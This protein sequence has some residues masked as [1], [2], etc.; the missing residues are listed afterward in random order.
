MSVSIIKF[1]ERFVNDDNALLSKWSAVHHKMIFEMHRQDFFV[2]STKVGTELRIE[3][4]G[5]FPASA[6][7]EVG[8]D[9]YIETPNGSGVFEV[10]QI[11][12]PTIII[13][14]IG[15]ITT[16]T[17]AGYINNLLRENYFIRTNIWGVDSANQYFFIGQSVNKP[18]TTGRAKVDVSSFL[19]EAVDYI[20]E[21]QYIVLNQKDTTLGGSYNITFS[22]NWT[23]FEG[24]F[25]GLSN[26]FLRF[27]VNSAKQ[28]QDVL[29]ENMGEYV[30]FFIDSV[31]AVPLAKF[32][33]DFDRPTYFPGFPF[34][35]SFIYSEYLAGIET[36]KHEEEFDINDAAIG[37]VDT[38]E[39]SN[40]EVQE[41]NRLLINTGYGSNVDDIDVW[42]E[43]DGTESCLLY[44]QE[45]FIQVG[46]VQD[47][48]GIPLVTDPV[49]ENPVL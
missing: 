48:C 18:D 36:F 10:I 47:V 24:E 11:I 20:D 16:L 33:S 13:I 29:G 9:I 14:E 4:T 49:E 3:I 37:P 17:G 34:S 1:P 23:G 45:G 6:E 35:L 32:L 46:Y 26:Q 42:L 38:K 44:Y 43:S 40:A 5:V 28:L 25:S 12:D 21:F 19:K 7:F 2:N 39:L 30:P 27:Y 8:E 41:V 22:E 15:A 31:T